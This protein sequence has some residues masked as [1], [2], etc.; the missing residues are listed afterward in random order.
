M[1]SAAHQSVLDALFEHMCRY[2]AQNVHRIQ[3]LTKVRAYA[4]YI[5][6]AEALPDEKQF[7]L[8]AV[9]LIHDI[10]IRP[11]EEKYGRHD[12]PYQEKEGAPRA[13][14][15]LTEF[16]FSPADAARG[17]YIVGHH[18]T[19]QAVDDTVFRIIMEADA[20][21]NL[22]ERG[23]APQGV[24]ETVEAVFRTYTGKR[25]AAHMYGEN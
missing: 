20:L 18:H 17:A 13:E 22:E 15:I 16:G 9:A 8:E 4:A 3:H 11:A 19:V 12:G 14:A 6:R 1:L 7:L 2:E 10:G 21:V 5:G 24:R 25:L 23:T